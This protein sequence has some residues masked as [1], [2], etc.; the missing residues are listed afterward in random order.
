V[1]AVDSIRSCSL[2]FALE[3]TSHFMKRWSI[4]GPPTRTL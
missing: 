1:K 3:A 2:V 4:L